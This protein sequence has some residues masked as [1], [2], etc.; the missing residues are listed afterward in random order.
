MGIIY[1]FIKIKSSKNILIR[2]SP[3][4]IIKILFLFFSD[5]FDQKYINKNIIIGTPRPSNMYFGIINF[6]NLFA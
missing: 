1:Q 2:K 4:I 6:I 5:I 3:K